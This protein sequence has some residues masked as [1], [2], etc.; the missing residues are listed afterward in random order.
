MTRKPSCRNFWRQVGSPNPEVKRGVLGLGEVLQGL[1]LHISVP[2]AQPCVL[3]AGFGELAALLGEAGGGLAAGLPVRVLLDGEVP[4]VPGVRAVQQHLLLLLARGVHAEPC[5]RSILAQEW[6]CEACEPETPRRSARTGRGRCRHR[7]PF[8]ELLA[9]LRCAARCHRGRDAG[10]PWR[11][12]GCPCPAPRERAFTP[13]LNDRAPCPKTRW[14]SAPKRGVG[15][16]GWPRRSCVAGAYRRDVA[17]GHIAAN[18]TLPPNYPC[19]RTTPCCARTASAPAPPPC[20]APATPSP[21]GRTPPRSG[22]RSARSP[23]RR[24]SRRPGTS[25]RPA[26]GPR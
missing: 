23:R 2:F 13:A 22:G 1:L 15:R 5:H 21:G 10:P 4:Y 14:D 24:R 6:S 17:P 19:R 18:Y 9:G 8:P 16:P 26:D 7:R 25:A 3:A 20:A 12:S 11:R